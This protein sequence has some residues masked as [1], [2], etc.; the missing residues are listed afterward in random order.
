M[1]RRSGDRLL[2]LPSLSLRLMFTEDDTHLTVTLDQVLPPIIIMR[3]RICLHVGAHDPKTHVLH[4]TDS[5]TFWIFFI[6]H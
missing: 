5:F 3:A 6:S 2:F 1:S 4:R